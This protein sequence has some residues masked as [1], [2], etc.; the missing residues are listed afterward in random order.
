MMKHFQRLP[1][2]TDN[3]ELIKRLKFYVTKGV[4]KG[5][6][7]QMTRPKYLLAVTAN[8][9]QKDGYYKQS[10]NGAI[11]ALSELKVLDRYNKIMQ[12]LEHT[13]A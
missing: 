4:V 12:S 10:R 6:T 9:T 3:K 5:C 8:K 7:W 13:D 1:K 2:E 11:L